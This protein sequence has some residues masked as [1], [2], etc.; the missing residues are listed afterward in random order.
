[1][2]DVLGQE[3]PPGFR[4]MSQFTDEELDEIHRLYE[5]GD[6]LGAQRLMLAAAFPDE[7]P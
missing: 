6:T 7:S 2:E 1:M 4:P 3:P 5:A